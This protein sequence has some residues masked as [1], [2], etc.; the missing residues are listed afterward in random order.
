[1]ENELDRQLVSEI[2]P[3]LPFG[4]WSWE[5]VY[6]ETDSFGGMGVFL[7]LWL[8][9]ECMYSYKEQ[10][11]EGIL[12]TYFHTLQ[13]QSKRMLQRALSAEFKPKLRIDG[14]IVGKY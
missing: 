14:D 4:D 8:D 10:L 1:M 6:E 12:T 13:A 5:I 7:Y 11:G 9:S 2:L 3:P